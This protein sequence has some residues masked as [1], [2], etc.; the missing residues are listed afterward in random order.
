[1][2]IRDRFS[3]VDIRVFS[4]DERSKDFAWA[5]ET[6]EPIPTPVDPGASIH[7]LQ[8]TNENVFAYEIDGRLRERDIKSAVEAV[9]PFLDRSGKFN[10]CLLYTSPSP[11]DS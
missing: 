7:F 9:K 1:M 11:R 3:S 8:T 2:C 4:H 6:P 5:S 10:V